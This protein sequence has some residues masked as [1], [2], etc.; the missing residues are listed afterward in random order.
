MR[1]CDFSNIFFCP[2]CS[3]LL[4]IPPYKMDSAGRHPKNKHWWSFHTKICLF[5]AWKKIFPQN[6]GLF[7]GDPN[8]QTKKKT[9]THQIGDSKLP[10]N[11]HPNFQSFMEI[12][13]NLVFE[14]YSPTRGC[15]PEKKLATFAW[16]ILR[17]FFVCFLSLFLGGD[18]WQSFE[19]IGGGRSLIIGG[20]L[21]KA[22]T[23]SCMLHLSYNFQFGER[24]FVFSA[25]CQF[26][27]VGEYP[28]NSPWR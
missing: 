22:M 7:N 6:G 14:D 1:R 16:M 27:R 15:C 25:A 26:R 3:K 23:N 24:V 4:N 20:K 19:P 9:N 21:T 13:K 17:T 18:R 28:L 5:G 10:Q 2:F 8:K 11:I 12:E